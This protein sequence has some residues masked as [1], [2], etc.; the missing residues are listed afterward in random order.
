MKKI[1][2]LSCLS[3]LIPCYHHPLLES[4]GLLSILRTEKSHI[5]LPE[6]FP[7][8]V[9]NAYDT[10]PSDLSETGLLLHLCLYLNF[11]YSEELS[12]TFDRQSA[13]LSLFL[14]DFI[15]LFMRDPDRERERGR[16]IG[17]GR[18]RLHAGSPM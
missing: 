5:F 16:D 18:G 1:K 15:Y 17:R 7:P 2:A 9:P 14:K 3:D 8:A 13:S 6:D 4:C 10:V 11:T 12:P